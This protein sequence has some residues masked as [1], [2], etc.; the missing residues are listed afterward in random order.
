MIQKG[1]IATSHIDKT[2]S[3]ISK[4]AL[5]DIVEAINADEGSVGIIVEHDP[6]V[7]PIGKVLKGE[8]IELDDGEYAIEAYQEI[9]DIADINSP[10][11]GENYYL[12]ESKTD[13]RRFTDSRIEE[14]H[15]LK[16]SID[17]INFDKK[18]FYEFKKS[19]QDNQ[20]DVSIS[21]RKALLPDPDILF[22]VLTSSLLV[23]SGR[24]VINKLSDDV[25]KDISDSYR[26]IKMAILKYAKYCISQ[27]RS[28]TY[29]IRECGEYVKELVVQTSDVDVVMEALKSDKIDQALSTI[30]ES[31]QQIKLIPAKVQLIY[32]END[33]KWKT[34]YILTVTGQAIGSERCFKR[35]IDLFSRTIRP[36]GTFYESVGGEITADDRSGE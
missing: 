15:R 13:L 14:I 31:L 8:L 33:G 10:N 28:Q 18:H 9:F 35:T 20:V 19:L 26:I 29:R 16:V 1:I 34:N 4:G 23:W 30:E 12:L 6:L 27:S 36:D 21:V 3:K 24:K 7:M 5:Q 32:D 17:P 25:A 22:S 11:F 2:G